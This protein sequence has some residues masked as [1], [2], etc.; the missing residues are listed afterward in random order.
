MLRLRKIFET[1]YDYKQWK[2]LKATSLYV[3]EELKK[4]KSHYFRED[5]VWESPNQNQSDHN[6]Q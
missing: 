6:S 5:F 2:I 4:I 1:L 3:L